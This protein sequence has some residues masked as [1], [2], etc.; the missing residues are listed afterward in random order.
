M[1]DKSIFR[2][3]WLTVIEYLSQIV[4]W[5]IGYFFGFSL[6]TM[7]SVGTVFA[8]EY[9]YLV[10]DRPQEHR[11]WVFKREG[12]I[13]LIAEV[14]SAIGWLFLTTVVWIAVLLMSGRI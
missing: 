11:Y 4:F 1:K 8:E 12:R 14:V 13:Y 9:V 5:G 6:V 10:R 2:G 7:L 3:S